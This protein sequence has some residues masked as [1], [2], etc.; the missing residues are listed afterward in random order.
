MKYKHLLLGVSFVFATT[1]AS[2][3]V[4]PH[5]IGLRLGGGSVSGAEIS[6]QH[7]LTGINRIEFD[8]GFANSNHYSAFSLSG[9][10]HWVHPTNWTQGMNW[11]IGP[12][13]YLG[14]RSWHSDY[15]GDRGSQFLLGINGQVGLEYNFQFPLQ[16]SLDL[17]P[18]LGIIGD[19]GNLDFD[20]GLGVRYYW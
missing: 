13:A 9:T 1:L 6:Y 20:L 19:S 17:R 7:G 3:Q 8:L 11:Y 18:R 14:G 5:A 2:A 4:N 16:V 10:Y 15:F 12:G